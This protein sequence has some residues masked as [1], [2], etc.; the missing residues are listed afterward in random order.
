M[1]GE[2][3]G[4]KEGKGV[5]KGAL[6]SWR[7]LGCKESV[8]LWGAIFEEEWDFSWILFRFGVVFLDFV[9]FIFIILAF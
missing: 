5:S 7:C 9:A 3:R 6:R 4:Q 8:F 2:W 1:R